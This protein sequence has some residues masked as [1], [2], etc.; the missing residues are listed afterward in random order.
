MRARSGP[1][2]F[3]LVPEERPR[4]GVA[5]INVSYADKEVFD[6]I[7][8]WLQHRRGVEQSQWDVFSFVLGAALES[9]TSGLKQARLFPWDGAS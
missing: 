9:E 6:A 4:R 8:L 7:Q 2:V 1:D 3:E 5:T